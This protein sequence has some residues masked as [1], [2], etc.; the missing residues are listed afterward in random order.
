[1]A[2]DSSIRDPD[3]KRLR[4]LRFIEERIKGKSIKE[5]ASEFNV[6]EDTVTRNLSYAKKAELVVEAEDKILRDLVPAAHEALKRALNGENSDVAAK[7]ALEIFK[8]TLPS[9]SKRPT[10]TGATSDDSGLSSYIAK[11]RDSAAL[12]ERTIDGTVVPPAL[13]GSPQRL[14]PAAAESAPQEGVSEAAETPRSPA[15]PA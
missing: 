13:E 9:F 11:L 10:A 4:A 3:L 5:I 12:A 14:L 15:D 8:G 7:A 1:M 6:S 2:G